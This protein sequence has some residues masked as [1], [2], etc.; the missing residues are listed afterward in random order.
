MDEA[1]EAVRR[2]S[3]QL[4]DDQEVGQEALVCHRRQL[5][6]ARSVVDR[7]VFR[8]AGRVER[9]GLEVAPQ[10]LW[11]TPSRR[12]LL[13]LLDVVCQKLLEKLSSHCW[14]ARPANCRAGAENA[15]RSACSTQPR[16]SED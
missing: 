11:I 7:L 15:P 10:A 5:V 6:D 3:R 9:V 14:R 12:G 1:L 4:L 8:D 16:T 13:Q 2:P